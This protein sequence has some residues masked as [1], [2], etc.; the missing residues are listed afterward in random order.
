MQWA[1]VEIVSACIVANAAFY[2]A[3]I[4][5]IQSAHNT[6][7]RRRSSATAPSLHWIQGDDS[8]NS[9]SPIAASVPEMRISIKPVNSVKSAAV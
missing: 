9:A 3:L 5:D 4:K 1:S 2:Y 8:R 7:P 6:L